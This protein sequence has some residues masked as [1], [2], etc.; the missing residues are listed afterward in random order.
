MIDLEN[1]MKME[2]EKK[3]E[4]VKIPVSKLYPFNNLLT[5]DLSQY[6]SK[7][8][9][10]PSNLEYFQESN[11]NKIKEDILYSGIPPELLLKVNPSNLKNYLHYV[12][13]YQ[14]F[15]S[16][17]FSDSQNLRNEY[18][19][20]W[21]QNI[22]LKNIRGKTITNI[23]DKE[24]SGNVIQLS[25]LLLGSITMTIQKF[26]EKSQ[27][28]DLIK[29]LNS[30]LN[31]FQKNENKI[32]DIKFE[33]YAAIEENLSILITLIFY[34]FK[35]ENEERAFY[36]LKVLSILEYFKSQRILFQILEYLEDEKGDYQQFENIFI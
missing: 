27:K 6:N 13:F 4:E 1:L 21:I 11:L 20:N 3:K 22:N 9:F 17:N 34:K 15:D 14:D 36:L 7:Q 24:N 19:E 25:N 18:L 35:N 16:E 30:L 31:S 10:V 29:S 5:L 26:L 33:M 28:E 2:M 12:N 23:F 8:K 32:K